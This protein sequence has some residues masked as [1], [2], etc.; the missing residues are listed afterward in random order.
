MRLMTWNVN[1][2][3]K[4]I[5][6]QVDAME[7]SECDI[8]ALQEVK[9]NTAKIFHSELKKL[10]FNHIT[11]SFI[12]SSNPSI[13]IG[14]RKY[15]ELIASKCP[16]QILP[17]QDFDVPWP[18]RVLSIIV[19]TSL[20]PLEIHTTHVPPGASNGWIKIETLEGIFKRLAIKSE[21]PRILCGDFNTPQRETPDGKVITWG[22]SGDRWDL[23]ERNVLVGLAEYNLP[24]VFRF[25][26]GYSVEEFSWYAR[27]HIGRRFDHIFASKEL[28]T[29]S[30][31]YYNHWVRENWLS[32]HSAMVIDFYQ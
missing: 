24:D 12:H 26:C 28:L 3:V 23:G 7:K 30:N 19:D 32:D 17:P 16:I 15:G 2:R 18:E 6:A 20:G 11:D 9:I 29:N 5:L 14:P 1:G 21:I 13:L 10:G 27:P 31:C 4:N 8:I 25:L 22:G